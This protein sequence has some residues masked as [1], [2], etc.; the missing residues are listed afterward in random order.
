MA[1][2]FEAYITNLGKYN[3][4]ELVGETLKFPTTTE[5]VQ[6]LLKRIGVDGVRYQTSKKIRQVFD[7]KRRNG[8]FI[9]S[10][11]PYG[12]V[13]DPGD[14]HAL[15]VDPEAAEVVKSIFSM[16][17]SGMNKRG[18]TYYLN[19]HGVLCPTAYKK[20]QGL[21]YNAPNAQSNPMWSTIT[22]WFK[23]LRA[24]I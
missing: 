16:F 11:A 13:K 5:E 6:A 22:I 14:K 2:L 19:D 17:L 20:Q 1:S 18:I 4:G 21:K 24:D 12:Y 23:R 9:G 8:E 3:E 10:Y 15:L 7:M